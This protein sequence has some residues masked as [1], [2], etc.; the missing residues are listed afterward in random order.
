IDGKSLDVTDPAIN[1][2]DP[3]F[4]TRAATLAAR[5]KAIYG[6]VDKIDPFVGIF[7][8]KHL[9]GSDL[10]ETAEAIW[11]KQFQ[12]M[13]DGDRFYFGNDQGLSF[14]KSTYGIDF[15]HTLAQIIEMN[16]DQTASNLNVT[17]DVFLAP[18]STLPAANCSVIYTISNV[19]SNTFQGT[20][21]IKNT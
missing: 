4:V 3:V 5:L 9:P 21:S 16:T 11:A 17:G 15:R 20:L 10:G 2:S 14:I 6:S 18:E 12:A 19:T 7:A 13:R 8:E 1:D